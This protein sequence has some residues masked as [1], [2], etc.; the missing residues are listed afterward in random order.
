MSEKHGK[1][2]IKQ[3]SFF[4]S[5]PGWEPKRTFRWRLEF[6][7]LVYHIPEQYIVS[8]QKPSISFARREVVGLGTKE[9]VAD[10]GSTRPIEIVC[11]DDEYSTVTNW[12]YYYY[13]VCGF[14]MDKEYSPEVGGKLKINTQAAKDKTRNIQISMLSSGGPGTTGAIGNPAAIESWILHGAWISE[15]SQSELNY[16][17]SGLA[18]YSLKIEYD[19]FEYLIDKNSRGFAENRFVVSSNLD[20]TNTATA[21]YTKSPQKVID[22]LEKIHGPGYKYL[23]HGSHG[24]IINKKA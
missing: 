21:D 8:V 3:R 10:L 22:E 20:F 23:N 1:R 11:V 2:P 15:F 4:W 12:I 13:K 19:H 5:D 6:D 7:N 18:T 9:I 14:H 17:D 16:K 24:D